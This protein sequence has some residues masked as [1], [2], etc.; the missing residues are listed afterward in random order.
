MEK[1]AGCAIGLD[2]WDRVTGGPT[3]GLLIGSQRRKSSSG[4]PELRGCRR[5]TLRLWLHPWTPQAVEQL[6]P[7]VEATHRFR[8]WQQAAAA[9]RGS[10]QQAA[11]ARLTRTIIAFNN[12]M[13]VKSQLSF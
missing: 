9:G 13:P 7:S 6:V 10:R 2:G 3:S 1:T 11:G 8:S 4:W 12:Q 5:P